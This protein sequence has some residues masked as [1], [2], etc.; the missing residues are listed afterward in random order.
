MHTG[1]YASC[2]KINDTITSTK[3]V[4]VKRQSE[5]RRNLYD[6]YIIIILYKHSFNSQ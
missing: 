2:T 4:L 6:V 1:V 5:M 3:I